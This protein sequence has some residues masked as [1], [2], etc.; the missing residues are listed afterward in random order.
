MAPVDLLIGPLIQCAEAATLGMPFEV[1]EEKQKV[2]GE[3]KP[4]L[5]KKATTT[6]VECN[7][8]PTHT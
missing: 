4:K 8:P 5:R 2:R 7:N 3:G 1:R 6:Y